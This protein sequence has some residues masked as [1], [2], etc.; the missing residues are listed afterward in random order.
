MDG[1]ADS[2]G[3][4]EGDSFRYTCKLK[5][6]DVVWKENYHISFE[7]FKILVIATRNST[8]RDS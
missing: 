8:L 7:N 2:A 1:D 4:K 3:M 6:Y 5:I